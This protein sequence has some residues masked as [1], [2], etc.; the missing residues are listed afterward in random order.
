MNIPSSVVSGDAIA[1]SIEKAE[2][3]TGLSP[4][5]F[6][7]AGLLV[8][9]NPLWKDIRTFSAWF[10]NECRVLDTTGYQE[11]IRIE[12]SC[13]GIARLPGGDELTPLQ[14]WRR[15]WT[16]LSDFGIRHFELDSRLESNQVSDILIMLFACRRELRQPRET[17]ADSLASRLRDSG[18]VTFACALTRIHG[19]TLSVTYSYCM[20]RFSKLVAWFKDRQRHLRDHRALFRA[21][22]KYGA[23]FGVAPLGVFL[24]YYVNGTASLLLVASLLAAVGIFATTFLFFMTVG[25]LVY[26]N[27]E[28]AYRLEKANTQLRLYADWIRG[29]LDRARAVQEML[30]PD[31]SDMP[32][33]DRLEWGA[34]FVPEEEVG[35]DYFDAACLEEGRVAVLFAD[36]SGHGLSAA[37]ITAI[38]KATFQGWTERGG[39]IEDF[40][41]QLN[42]RLYNLT[43]RQSFAAVAVG[44]LDLSSVEFT[45]C[46]CGHNP[47]P[48]VIRADG[49]LPAPLDGARNLILGALEEISPVTSRLLLCSGDTVFFATDGITEASNPYGEEFAVEGLEQFLSEHRSLPVEEMVERLISD[50]ESHSQNAAGNDDRAV[51]AFRVR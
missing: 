13:E 37:L 15:L 43:P 23:V 4:L 22:P 29:D 18:G 11:P 28:K 35:G 3:V 6:V 12:I 19:D 44:I 51:L 47:E 30:L 24:L 50:V 7:A 31:L 32:L 41:R 2:P 40:I 34:S 8:K 14:S 49:E 33:A 39:P 25:S 38:I 46:N 9:V 21:A 42:S 27:E 10:E 1:A 48:Y 17:S 45:Y 26:D 20:T 16:F 36:V 5:N